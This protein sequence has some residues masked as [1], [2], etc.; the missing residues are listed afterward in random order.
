[1]TNLNRKALNG[2]LQLTL[3]I[4]FCIFVPAWTVR[5]WQGWLLLSV[6]FVSFL[7][8]TVYLMKYDQPLL[9]RR[10]HAGPT[11]EKYR[12][13]KIGQFFAT[14]AFLGIFVVAGLDHRFAWSSVPTP[15]AVTGDVL[16]LLGLLIVF[17]VFRENS[18]TSA[19]V[20]VAPGQRVISTG[21]YSVVRH[22]MYIAALIM[23]VGVPLALGSW[24]GV[25]P[26]VLMMLV[27]VRRVRDEEQLLARD[28]DGYREYRNQV[29]YR[30]VPFVW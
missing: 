15:A 7:A 6:L 25:A 9:E 26:T 29:R 8:I 1:M 14:L 20:E 4:A 30:L 23:L 18:F 27:M 11:A 19:I 16:V 3:T 28:L 12:S 10:I 5:F 17:F 2:L 24:W 21:P 13:Q 22:P